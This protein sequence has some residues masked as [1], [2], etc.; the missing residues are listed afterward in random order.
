MQR[1]QSVGQCEHLPFLVRLRMVHPEQMQQSVDGQELELGV[2]GDATLGRLAVR[3]RGTDDD[4]AE[5]RRAC[6]RGLAR[7]VHRERQ[8]VGRALVP[9]VLQVQPGDRVLIDEQQG[10][11]HVGRDAALG[12]DAVREG[13]EVLDVDV[14]VLLVREEDRHLRP[15]SRW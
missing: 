12:E 1:E 3:D 15:S 11:L 14:A 7:L 4:V 13:D 5:D 2:D 6:R 8:H 10:D 9:Q